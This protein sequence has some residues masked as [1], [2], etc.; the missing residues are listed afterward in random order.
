MTPQ[1]KSLVQGTWAMVVPISDVAAT[2]FYKR[3]FELDPSLQAL[4]VHTSMPEQRTKL[5]TM[6]GAAV[7]GLG[8]LAAIVPAVQD[9]GRRHVGYGVKDE[10]YATVGTA[11]LWTLEQ[12][13][14]PAFTPQVKEAWTVVYGVLAGTMKDAARA[15]A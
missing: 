8:D 1:Q 15:A 10:H 6:I 7:A 12:G 14:G 9:M 4:F 13:L 5:M 3:L 2:M 11:L